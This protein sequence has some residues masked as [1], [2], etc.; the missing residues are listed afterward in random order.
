MDRSELQR[1]LAEVAPTAGAAGE[2][3]NSAFAELIVESIDPQHITLEIFNAFLPTRTLNV[4]DQLVKRVRRTGHPVRTMVP[5]TTHLSDPFYPP[6]ETV[7][8]MIDY[9]I[10]KTGMSVW[11]LRRGE[12]GTLEQFRAEMESALIDELVARVYSLLAQVWDGTT[13]RTNFVDATATGLTTNIL[14]GMIETVL[15]KAG[16]VRAIVG[17]RAA[18]LPIY[19]TGG[20][21]EVQPSFSQNTNGVIGLQEILTE[22]RRTGRLASFRG[23]PLVELPQVFKRDANGFDVPLIDTSRVLVIGD[24]AGEIVLYGGVESQEHTDTSI[25]PPH[26]TL[27][28]WRAYGLIVDAMENIGVI[29]VNGEPN[30]PYAIS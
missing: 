30:T 4:G 28:I 19:R 27:A 1:A 22:W 11:E 2:G 13:S 5:G 9:I 20:I 18:L 8:Y 14:D 3:R 29:K 15:Y 16:S 23:I 12:L 24:N 7:N 10:A 25:E 26:Y 17:T 21:V 6:R